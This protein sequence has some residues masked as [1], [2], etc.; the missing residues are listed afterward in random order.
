MPPAWRARVASLKVA[1]VVTMSSTNR[2]HRPSSKRTLS[3]RTPSPAPRLA[4]QR[5]APP[6]RAA[7]HR[8]PRAGAATRPATRPASSGSSSATS[9]IATAKSGAVPTVTDVRDA[10]GLVAH[11]FEAWLD[12]PGVRRELE[13]INARDDFVAQRRIEMHAVRLE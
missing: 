11:G 7:H 4:R 6:P 9:A 8:R 5:Q 1:P 10:P 3:G 12:E 2:T 13:K